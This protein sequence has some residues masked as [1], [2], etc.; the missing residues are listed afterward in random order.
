MFF[1]IVTGI[2]CFVGGLLAAAL[3]TDKHCNT[4]KKEALFCSIAGLVWPLAIGVAAGFGVYENVR[5]KIM[6]RRHARNERLAKF[7]SKLVKIKLLSKETYT[8]MTKRM[9]A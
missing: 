1:Y 8:E 6:A 4:N 7:A 9:N 2:Y 3:L 5:E